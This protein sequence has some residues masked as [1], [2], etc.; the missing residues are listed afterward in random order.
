MVPKT[1]RQNLSCKWTQRIINGKLSTIF[2]TTIYLPIFTLTK[3]SSN[4]KHEQFFY[5]TLILTNP[6]IYENKQLKINEQSLEINQM[7]VGTRIS[8]IPF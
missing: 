2:M 6:I 7:T 4:S 8:N 1:Y 5:W 3:A